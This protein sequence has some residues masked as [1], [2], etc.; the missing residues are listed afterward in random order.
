MTFYWLWK[1]RLTESRLPLTSVRPCS[2]EKATSISR[3][4]SSALAC[5]AHQQ[6]R[7]NWA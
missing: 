2:W 5:G 7:E 3:T 6:A 1:G 4:A